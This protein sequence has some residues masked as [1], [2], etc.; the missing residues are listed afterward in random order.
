MHREAHTTPLPLGHFYRILPK[1]PSHLQTK[2][3]LR[4]FGI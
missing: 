4:L 2:L 3:K 1:V